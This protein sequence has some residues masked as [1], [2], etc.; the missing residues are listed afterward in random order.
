M[1]MMMT[2]PEAE[3]IGWTWFGVELEEEAEPGVQLQDARWGV[4]VSTEHQV[5]R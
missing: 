4:D 2:T 5:Q 3:T 1:M